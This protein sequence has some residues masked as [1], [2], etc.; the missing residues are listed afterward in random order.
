[1]HVAIC[2]GGVIG[3]AT[4]YF[5][6]EPGVEATMV[7]CCSIAAAASGKA[8]GFL[9]RDWCDDNAMGP[10]ARASFELHNAVFPPSPP[11]SSFRPT[12]ESSARPSA[13]HPAGSGFGP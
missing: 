10:L 8:G 1:M 4:A 7:E 3:A 6:A 13:R 11:P 9:A 2:G 5:L 12:R